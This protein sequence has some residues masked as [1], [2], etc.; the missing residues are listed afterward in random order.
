MWSE[1]GMILF[2]IISKESK[3]TWKIRKYGWYYEKWSNQNWLEQL[4][5]QKERMKKCTRT[6]TEADIS[7]EV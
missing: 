1:F 3:R 7:V 4:K 5:Q 6:L 2:V